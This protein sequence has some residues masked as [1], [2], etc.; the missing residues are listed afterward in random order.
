MKIINLNWQCIEARILAA[1]FIVL[2]LAACPSPNEQSETPNIIPVTNITGV[3]ASATAGTPLTLNG[4]VSPSN[5][6]NQTIV[7]S[8]TNAGTTGA[9]ITGNTLNTTNTGSVTIT[10]T[11]VNGQTAS[12]NYTQ[13]FTV[14]VNAAFVAVSNITG[15]PA[16]ATVGTP[17]TLSGTVS[18]SNATNQTI[19]LVGSKR[20]GYCQR[21]HP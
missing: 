1:S 20:F 18:P 19:C 9:T 16:S 6:T 2:V 15:I 8:V 17:L 12:T 5:A 11:V 10:A 4:T 14:T 21:K 3:P 13:N 7:W